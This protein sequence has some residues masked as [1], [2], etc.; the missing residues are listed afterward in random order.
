MSH[1]N[2]ASPLRI[3]VAPS[4]TLIIS[5][6]AL[7]IGTM[8]SLALIS[9]VWFCQLIL[10]VLVGISL[11]LFL[12]LQ[13]KLSGLNV[14]DHFFPRICEATW[15]ND[16]AWLLTTVDGNELKAQLLATSFVHPRIT[17]INLKLSGKPWYSR[18]RSLIF[19]PDNL[20]KEI[21]RRLRIRLR[22]YSLPEQDSSVVLK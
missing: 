3:V 16:D 21:F 2:Y 4:K 15:G 1:I 11:W 19:L 20:D 10:V 17:I 14:T 22:W 8:M 9:V 18:Y 5:V 13:G 7:H 6:I 12:S